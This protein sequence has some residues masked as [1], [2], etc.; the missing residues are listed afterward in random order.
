VQELLERGLSALP[1]LLEALERRDVDMRAQAH[2]FLQQILGRPVPFDPYATEAQRRQQI[3][4]LREQ[5]TR[6]AG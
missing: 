2:M 5:M 1:S 4:A 6:K 3:L